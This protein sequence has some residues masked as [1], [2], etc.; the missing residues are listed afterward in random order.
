MQRPFFS[1]SPKRVGSRPDG[2]PDSGGFGCCAVSRLASCGVSAP[3]AE[4]D[5][6]AGLMAGGWAF[7]TGANS[8][9]IGSSRPHEIP[10]KT[11]M[12]KPVGIDLGGDVGALGVLA[13]RGPDAARF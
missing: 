6:D 9:R 11:K 5:K 4:T 10:E 1:Q 8:A 3:E 12:S 2:P 13:F 7:G